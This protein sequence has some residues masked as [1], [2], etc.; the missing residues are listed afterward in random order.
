[1]AHNCRFAV[2]GGPGAGKTTLLE[3]LRDRGFSC[4]GDSAR[5]LIRQRLHA[6]LPPRPKPQEFAQGIFLADLDNYQLTPS[7][8]RAVF[9]DRSIID[10]LAMLRQAA[11]K[12]DQEIR[13]CVGKYPYNAV[14]FVLPPWQ[15]IYRT[16][17]ERDQTFAESVAV[18]N[19]VV[20]WYAKCG[21]QTVEVPT[22]ALADRVEFVE[23]TVAAILV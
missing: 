16:D 4:A 23:Q 10:A 22:G 15:E 1:M 21:Y 12:S 17:D 14:A 7:S 20:S 8:Q 11:V 3:I 19:S 9:F 13:R 5:A 18:F 6:G 2:S